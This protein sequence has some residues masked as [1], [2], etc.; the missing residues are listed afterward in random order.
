MIISKEVF[1]L[2][3]KLPHYHHIS[4]IP[5]DQFNGMGIISPTQSDLQK[6][7][8][9]FEDIHISIYPQ[10]IG[11]D[12]YVFM[13]R[14]MYVPLKFRNAKRRSQ[15]LVYF[16]SYSESPGTYKGGWE[17]YEDALEQALIHSIKIVIKEFNEIWQS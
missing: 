13:Y 7:L 16:E 1:D 5:E 17:T 4:F 6:Y 14:L 9:E 8:R 12:E 15:H 10:W 11:S 3:V 2:A